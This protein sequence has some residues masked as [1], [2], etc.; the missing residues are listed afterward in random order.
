MGGYRQLSSFECKI[1]ATLD[2]PYFII[3]LSLS[4]DVCRVSNLIPPLTYHGWEREI[5]DTM[6]TSASGSAAVVR[7]VG[8]RSFVSSACPR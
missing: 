6:R 8:R 4:W 2:C 5:N 3:L 1:L 7:R